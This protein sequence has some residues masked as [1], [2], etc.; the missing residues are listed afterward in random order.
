M[1]VYGD[2]SKMSKEEAEAALTQVQGRRAYLQ[3]YG[4]PSELRELDEKERE[5]QRVA[6][7]DSVKESENDPRNI[8]STEMNNDDAGADDNKATPAAAS[9]SSDEASK[10]GKGGK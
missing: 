4:D 2:V 9:S 6:D 3:L 5:L 1:S 8:P 7:P 10:P